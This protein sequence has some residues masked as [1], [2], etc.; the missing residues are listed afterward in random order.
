MRNA[1]LLHRFSFLGCIGA[2]GLAGQTAI[3]QDAA[4]PAEAGA[5]EEVEEVLV[6]GYRASLQSATNAK[7]ESVGFSDSVFAEDIGKF[8]DLNIAESLNRI[9]GVQLT[10]EVT[11]EGLNIAI[12]G[13]NTNFTKTTI[14]GA[15]VGVASTGRVDS[16]GQ[17]RE[18]DLDLFPT[19]L[20]TRLDVSKS[21]VASQLEGGAAGTVNMRTARPFDNPGTHFNY[22][23]QASYSDASEAT[24]PR[25]SLMG[26]WSGEK[27]GVLVGF[28]GV[29]TDSTTTGFETIGYTNPNLS[30]LQCGVA[31]PVT[32][33]ATSP[34][35]GAGANS[36]CNVGGG[37]G[38]VI[39]G[40]VPNNAG[41][42][43]VAGTVIDGAYLQQINPGLT[44]GQID[45]AL[46]PRLG[47][48]A[49][50]DGNRDRYSGLVS[51]EYRAND[52]LHFYFDTL[53][54]KAHRAFNRLDL[55][56]VGRNGSMIPTAM[57]VDENNVVTSATIANAQW[58]LEARPYD[59]QVDFWGFNPGGHWQIN[60]SVRMDFAINKSRSWFF[61]EAPTILVNSPL[62]QG[63]TADF[64]NTG[65][66]HV[67][68]TPSADVNDPALGWTWAGGGRVNVQ[69]E[70]RL[71]TNEGAHLDFTF[72]DA[73]QNIKV[74][75]AYDQMH[76]GISGRDN[77]R[78]WQQE[79][80]GGGGPFIPAPGTAPGCNGQAG[81]AVGQADL[82]QY[83]TA[84]P[85]GFITVDYDAFFAATNYHEY[86]R[87]A[88][89]GT[90][91]ATGAANGIIEEDTMGY[92]V[93]LNGRSE[94]LG[95]EVRYNLGGRFVDTDQFVAGPVTLNNGTTI[96]IVQASNDTSYSQFLPSLNAA[97]T[98]RDDL[99][100]RFASSRTITRASPR[101]MLP[102]AQFSD[103]SAQA[104]TVGNP[105]LAPYL[106][107]N[108]D[109]GGEWYTG[110]E[111]YV[112]LTLFQKQITGFT[113]G[114][115][116]VVPFSTLAPL[117][118][119]FDTLSPTQQTA[120]TSRGGP[121]LATVNQTR[122]INAP[123]QLN[124][125]GYEVTWVQPLSFITEGFGFQA[126]YTNV[127]Q[128]TEGSTAQPAV[129]VG[130]SPVTYNATLYYDNGPASVRL[131]FV[132]NDEQISSGTNQEGI[133]GARFWT[134]AT[135]QLDLSASYKL[136]NLP[137]APQITLN[138]IN[139]TGE[140]IRQTWGNNSQAFS[141]AA[142]AFYDPGYAVL[143]G[144]R[145]TF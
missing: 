18:L 28:A 135:N 11:G 22:Q 43:L 132:H 54:S 80:C 81:S 64:D 37:N 1:D 69:N 110:D 103:P 5:S 75:L 19:E 45:Q 92:Y 111:G 104:L 100:L 70:K 83:L 15:A 30:Y 32:T 137:S 40:A 99:V 90:G 33:P 102:N 129:A 97:L 91:A 133:T 12:R 116:T 114:E 106:S 112:G 55:N 98:L 124:I 31:P 139:I 107:T 36:G 93:E 76:R 17:N 144:I 57:Q 66:D 61:R 125:R 138:V 136:E 142:R 143:L 29:D 134:D 79:V 44:L 26:S 141:N 118:I 117:G 9:P 88:P 145:G 68:I 6:T 62:N 10:R 51:L 50:I 105:T 47:R 84:G 87:N 131:S 96:T 56:L 58:F 35:A 119:T 13:L 67:T 115:L 27:F 48:P 25:G 60:D 77:S 86:S 101:D 140:T 71:V 8:P 127:K 7:R 63:I 16:Q 3:A 4:A 126:N 73:E 74:G 46:F 89:V 42:G 52:D 123:G 128:S 121:N 39:P 113:V 108:I 65:G 24:S 94:V 72:G 109:L 78:A 85:A 23:L 59:E 34:N 82:A 41:A 38:W 120:I 53:Y 14:N 95:K 122:Q 20:F 2:V 21:P 49:Y 130:I